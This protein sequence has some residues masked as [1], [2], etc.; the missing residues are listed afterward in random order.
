M[1]TTHHASIKG[2]LS[3]E[4]DLSSSTLHSRIGSAAQTDIHREID[5]RLRPW[6]TLAGTENLPIQPNELHA[7]VGLID[8]QTRPHGSPSA[9]TTGARLQFWTSLAREEVKPALIAAML[10]HEGFNKISK[11]KEANVFNLP[12]TEFLMQVMGSKLD[13]DVK[14]LAVLVMLKQQIGTSAIESLKRLSS[15]A[16]KSEFLARVLAVAAKQLNNALKAA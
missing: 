8:P 4:S 2:T 10:S 14:A 12:P 13:M 7:A 9:I 15:E 3:G 6:R 1:S 16:E 11:L 5:T